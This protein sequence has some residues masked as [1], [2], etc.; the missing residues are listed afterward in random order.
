ML[1]KYTVY[2]QNR[3]QIAYLDIRREN[4]YNTKNYKNVENLRAK[5]AIMF[6]ETIQAHFFNFLFSSICSFL[7][8]Q[9]MTNG[10]FKSPVHRVLT[11]TERERLSV[12]MFYTPEPN[13]EIGPEDDL[14]SEEQPKLFKKVKNYADI[15]WGY[16]QQ[17]LRA[18][19]VAQV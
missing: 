5:T 19:H 3:D 4:C 12:A 15:H 9:I 2:H 14:V 11:N 8:L 13:K 6:L 7:I 1:D 10:V 16:Y 17:G 18:I